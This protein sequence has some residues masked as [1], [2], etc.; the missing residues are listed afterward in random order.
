MWVA[1]P[2][3]ISCAGGPTDT[4]LCGFGGPGGAQIVEEMGEHAALLA[5]RFG[6]LVDEWGTVNEPINY[7]LA[8]YGVGMFPPGKITLVDID[9]EFVPALRDY[10]AAHAAM[11]HAIKANDTIDADGDG[12]AAAVGFSLSV[13]DW[14]PARGNKPSTNPDDIAA[15]DRLVYMFHYAF[16]DAVDERHVRRD[17]D[18]T[19]DEQHPEWAGTLDWLGLQYYFR[20]GVSGDAPL[21]AGP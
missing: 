21:L 8:A 19:P 6:D 11:Y 5:Q 18:G 2:R 3:D 7:M 1:D 4:N 16:V 10:I 9:A 12:V 14:E 15:R 13:A 20:A 17:L